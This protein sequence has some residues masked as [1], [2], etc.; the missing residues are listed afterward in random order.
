[1]PGHRGGR[2]QAE[3]AEASTGRRRE[4]DQCYPGAGLS[5]GRLAESGYIPTYRRDGMASG[6]AFGG[7]HGDTASLTSFWTAA[8]WVWIWSGAGGTRPRTNR[9]SASAAASVST[10]PSGVAPAASICLTCSRSVAT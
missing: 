2:V 4:G 6:A 8:R 5:D 9:A 1:G 7:G 3:N 10:A